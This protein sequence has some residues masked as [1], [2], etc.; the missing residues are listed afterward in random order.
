MK[1]DTATPNKIE[2]ISLKKSTTSAIVVGSSLLA[3]VSMS[4]ASLIGYDAYV[5][6]TLG[7]LELP[8][9]SWSYE[10]CFCIHL[11]SAHLLKGKN[12]KPCSN[13][14]PLPAQLFVRHIHSS[15][16]RVSLP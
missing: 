8:L 12:A 3:S 1:I 2:L 4:P 15:V 6:F 5:C 10:L 13:M 14:H 16:L 7:I 9:S 11:Q